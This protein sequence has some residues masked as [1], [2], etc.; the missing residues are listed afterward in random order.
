MVEIVALKAS[1]Q[2]LHCYWRIIN[3]ILEYSHEGVSNHLTLFD[4]VTNKM[5]ART[6]K[7]NQ[8]IFPT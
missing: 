2:Y 6:P 3:V 7:A 4:K 5:R 1:T 8:A